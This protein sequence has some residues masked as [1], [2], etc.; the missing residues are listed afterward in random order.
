MEMLFDRSEKGAWH[1]FEDVSLHDSTVITGDVKIGR[2]T[3]VGP[4]CN[5]DGSGGLEIGEYCSVAV[6][7]RIFSHDSAKWA[8]SRGKHKVE[9]SATII[10]DRC[11]IGSNA[12]VT[13]GVRIGRCSVV[14]AGAVVT[15]DIPSNTIVAG[16]PARR[17]GTVSVEGDDVRFLMD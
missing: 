12:I 4:Q 14:G 1:G 15:R 7:A 3:F 5:L 2:G 10:E 16:T 11:F 17:I 8:V 6:G 13:K 9:R